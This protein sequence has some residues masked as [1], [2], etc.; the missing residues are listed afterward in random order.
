NYDV[1]QPITLEK[2]REYNYGRSKVAAAFVDAGLA[3]L[4]LGTILEF[5]TY[6]TECSGPY[7][8]YSDS[9][10]Y[11]RNERG[12]TAAHLVVITGLSATGLSSWIY[13]GMH[14]KDRPTKNY[15]EIE[16]P[17]E[18]YQ[19]NLGDQTL[20]QTVPAIN[21][22]VTISSTYFTINGQHT[23]TVTS[24]YNGQGKVQLVPASSNYSF[25]LDGLSETAFAKD[26]LAHGRVDKEKLL[27][28]LKQNS[29][30]ATYD[31]IL[32]VTP[33]HGDPVTKKVSINGFEIPQRA[34]ENIIMGL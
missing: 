14:K 32:S 22:P 18:T 6:T 23:T 17:A 10:M 15:R 19:R 12:S 16:V 29:T 3:T 11:C 34:M 13:W 9:T 1:V 27:S 24:D 8:G 30:P 4:A 5:T 7:G 33:P 2:Q 26:V 20:L 31:V 25:T 21:A 28:E